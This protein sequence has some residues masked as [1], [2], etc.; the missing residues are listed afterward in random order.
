MPGHDKTRIVGLEQNQL[1]EFVC[2]ICQDVL[3]K[4]VV[5]Q[6]CRQSYCRDCI[7]EW[8]RGH[9]TCPNDRQPLTI[10]G[11]S[12]V[13]RFVINLIDK[14]KITC[15]NSD[16]GC[17]EVITI[18]TKKYHLKM[19]MYNQCKTC[20][21]DRMGDEH[22]CLAYLMQKN[23]ELTETNDKLNKERLEIDKVKIYQ[24][25]SL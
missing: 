1:E 24:F 2:G 11:V 25:G 7:E 12:E 17:P 9:Y 16:K 21:C 18:G 23:L 10:D 19:C 4:P 14:L 20:G 15:D 3:N 8:L 5:T 22:D 6:C 13:P